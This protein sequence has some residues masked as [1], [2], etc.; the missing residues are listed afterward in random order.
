[1]RHDEVVQRANQLHL[2]W[3]EIQYAVDQ[4]VHAAWEMRWRAQDTR[5]AAKKTIDQAARLRRQ[6]AATHTRRG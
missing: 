4:S 6:V 1:M 5:R 2:R 3:L